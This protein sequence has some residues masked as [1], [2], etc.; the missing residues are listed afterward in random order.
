MRDLD[1]R[2]PTDEVLDGFVSW[3][4]LEDALKGLKLEFD[5]FAAPPDPPQPP[6]SKPQEESPK[7]DQTDR[8]PLMQQ[9]A[10]DSDLVKTADQMVSQMTSA[11]EA[12]VDSTK[13]QVYIFH[14]LFL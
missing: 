13:D 8:T 2:M 9:Q 11:A 7:V 4:T 1:D 3:S 6:T 5:Q 14:H 12:E 10:S